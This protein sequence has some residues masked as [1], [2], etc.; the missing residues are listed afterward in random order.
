MPRIAG[1]CG[2][3]LF[4]VTG[5][6]SRKKVMP[7]IYDL[8]NRGLLPPGF[9]LVGYA[10]RDWADEDFAQIV[11][12][13]VREHARTEFR[14]EVWRQLAEGFR[15]VQGDFSDDVPFDRLRRTIE[16]LDEVRG[17]QGNHAFYLSIPPKFFGDVIGQLEE[18]GLTDGGDGHLAAGRGG[19]AVRARPGVRARAQRTINKVFPPES[20]FRIDH[21]L[22]KE[23]VQN[24]LAMRFANNLFEPIWNANY[25]DHVQITMAEDIGIGGRAGYY[26]GIGAAR[27]VI[28]NHLMQLLALVAMEEPLSFDAESLR[29]EK[30]K[31][32]ASV[33]LPRRLDLHTARGQYAA[34]WAGGEKVIGYLDE[35]DI[36][37]SSTTETYAAIRLDVETRRW[38]G[39]PFYLRTGKRLG[40]RVTE[41]AVVLQAGAAPAVQRDRDRG[42]DAQR[43]R[44]PDPARRGHHHPV[45]LQGAGHAPWRSATST[46]TSP[47]AARSP[48]TARRPT[49]GS[50][51]TCCWA[52]RRCSRSTR[53]SSSPG[54]SSTR[55]S[56][57]GPRQDAGGKRGSTSTSPATGVRSPPTRCWPARAGLETAVTR[58][59]R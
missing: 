49:S 58:R 21:Y 23:T 6:L 47:T 20:V 45:R 48:R 25:V 16:D 31:V 27:D 12:D 9:S 11:H 44:L 46:W 55:S 8:A 26:D 33:A 24:I 2:L 38:A 14:E 32:L 43:D 10:R 50:S 37:K 36:E 1:P 4:G 54:R 56:S 35:E 17:T 30:Q 59:P 57:T 18:H 51:S 52:T 28:Q 39:V 29:A 5:D 40:R 15:F 22:G 34:G 42:P 7:A 3:V 19:E 13:S 53:R 41:V